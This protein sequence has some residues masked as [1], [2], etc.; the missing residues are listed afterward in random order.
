VRKIA[1][2]SALALA[3][4]LTLTSCGEPIEGT[5]VDKLHKPDLSYWSND[6]YQD[7]TTYYSGSGTN[8]R[9]HQRCTTRWRNNWH[10]HPEEWWL[11]VQVTEDDGD[12][13]VKRD[14]VNR[15]RYFTVSIG[16]HYREED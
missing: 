15:T 3:G 9:S 12:Q 5:V 8:R 13:K 11:Y 4:A 16:D 1:T 7:C 2:L 6:P 14:R 10:H